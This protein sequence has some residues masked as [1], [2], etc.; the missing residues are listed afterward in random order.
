MKSEKELE[1]A[2]KISVDKD[3]IINLAI[4]ELQP[5]LDDQDVFVKLINK[6][7]SEILDKNPQ[8]RYKLLVNIIAE[9]KGKRFSVNS[10]K[11]AVKIVS[12]ERLSKTVVIGSNIVSKV[13]V[14]FIIKAAGKDGKMKWF[15]KKE[16]N[17]ALKWLKEE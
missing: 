16:E 14:N 6:A 15:T 12:D 10:R 2:L 17:Q 7:I 3:N 9:E 1:Q 13:I 4:L 11:I 8:K 5:N